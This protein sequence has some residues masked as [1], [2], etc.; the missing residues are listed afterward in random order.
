MPYRVYPLWLR[1][2]SRKA[3]ERKK[4]ELENRIREIEGQKDEVRESTY[5][6]HDAL[7]G[8]FDKEEA[9]GLKPSSEHFQAQANRLREKH[10]KKI[11][12]LEA[13]QR[14]AETRILLIKQELLRSTR[15]R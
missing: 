1:L 4:Q 15:K 14:L 5:R 10:G 9:E 7:A 13:K 11:R 3:L 6:K 8:E 2:H 12:R